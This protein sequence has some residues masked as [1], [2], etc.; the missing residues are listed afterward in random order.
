MSAGSKGSDQPTNESRV[1]GI[2]RK[3]DWCM[4]IEGQI[5]KARRVVYQISNDL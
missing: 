3:G 2:K 4:G 1:T 5:T